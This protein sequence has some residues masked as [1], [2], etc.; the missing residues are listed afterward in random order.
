MFNGWEA[1]DHYHVYT[2]NAPM[3]AEKMHIKSSVMSVAGQGKAKKQK[4]H[5][6]RESEL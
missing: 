6:T 5:L 4:K 2:Q 3:H 1:Y